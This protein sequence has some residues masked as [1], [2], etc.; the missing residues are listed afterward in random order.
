MLKLWDGGHFEWIIDFL[1][2][3]GIFFFYMCERGEL[4]KNSELW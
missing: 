1:V 2:K 4:T 3:M